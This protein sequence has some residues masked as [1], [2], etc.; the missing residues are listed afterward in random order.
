[1]NRV[2]IRNQPS[3]IFDVVTQPVSVTASKMVNLKCHIIVN[4]IVESQLLHNLLL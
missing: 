4:K 3:H 2:S 1:M